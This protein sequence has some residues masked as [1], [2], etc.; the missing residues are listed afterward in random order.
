MADGPTTEVRLLTAAEAAACRDDL[1]EVL[2]DCVAGGASISFMQ[3][4]PVAEAAAWWDGVIRSVAAGGTL[5]F[6]AFRDGRAVG[7]VQLGIDQPPNQPHRADV[8][9]V[10]VHRRARGAGIGA[11]LMRAA[12]AEAKRRGLSLLVLDTV[13]GSDAEHLYRRLGWSFTGTI[14]N[15]AYMPDGGSIAAT[16]IYWKAL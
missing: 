4:F 13:S 5:L 14:P 11:A 8:K 7:S 1:A 12:E 16:A 3:P 6:A 2:A 15:Y 9:K 10:I